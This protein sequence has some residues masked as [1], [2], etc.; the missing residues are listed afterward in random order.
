MRSPI[1]LLSVVALWCL[2]L[3]ADAQEYG[4]ADRGVMLDN[5]IPQKAVK[6]KHRDISE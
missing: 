3:P 6:K 4:A 1:R 5:G 2:V